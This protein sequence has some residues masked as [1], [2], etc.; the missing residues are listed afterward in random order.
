[1]R[2]AQGQT[3][4]AKIF[5]ILRVLNETAYSQELADFTDFVHKT[6]APV[7]L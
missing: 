7:Y 3:V 1:M 5:V 4:K 2:Q 6:N